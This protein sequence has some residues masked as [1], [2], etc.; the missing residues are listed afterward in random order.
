M[1]TNRYAIYLRGMVMKFQGQITLDDQIIASM[2]DGELKKAVSK[3]GKPLY[4]G[5][6]TTTEQVEFS[7]EAIYRLTIE[8]GY[9][10]KIKVL[11]LLSDLG[12]IR[13]YSCYATHW[14]E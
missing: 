13:V 1:T 11:G 4:R 14:F 6:I 3:E 12:G 8:D 5:Y 2:V 10:T 7:L 9:R